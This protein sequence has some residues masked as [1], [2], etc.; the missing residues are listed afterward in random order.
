[1]KSSNIIIILNLPDGVQDAAVAV[2]LECEIGTGDRGRPDA[3]AAV[4][5]DLGDP[6]LVDVVESVEVPFRNVG[7]FKMLFVSKLKDTFCT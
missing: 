2:D 7:N 4:V 5:V 3:A 6:E 1:M